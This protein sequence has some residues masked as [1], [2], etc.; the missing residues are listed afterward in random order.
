MVQTVAPCWGAVD[1]CSG[2]CA[3]VPG[4]ID[5]WLDGRTLSQARSPT[6]AV[7]LH[8]RPRGQ[9][10]APAPEP[11]GDHHP[12]HQIRWRP[13][14]Q[15]SSAEVV[16]H[17]QVLTPAGSL[18]ACL[19]RWQNPILSSALA[20]IVL[21]PRLQ[22]R[23]LICSDSP[24]H[25]VA[26]SGISPS[27]RVPINGCALTPERVWGT[28]PCPICAT[29]AVSFAGALRRCPSPLSRGHRLSPL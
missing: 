27:N 6:E 25:A 9:L 22:W 7:R 11:H 17:R 14:N 28:T 10:A 4:P 26:G 16:N 3:D 5:R 23:T 12:A 19:R 21:T 29:I 13:V 1:R 20:Q 15:I 24:Q 8:P 18:D 2:D